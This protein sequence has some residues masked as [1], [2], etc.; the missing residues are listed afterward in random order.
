M[1]KTYADISKAIKIIF[2]EQ[3]NV[4]TSFVN[5]LKLAGLKKAYRVKALKHHPDRAETLGI[6]SGLLTRRFMLIRRAYDILEPYASGQKQLPTARPHRVKTV[7]RR[8]QRRAKAASQTKVRTGNTR[9][10]VKTRTPHRDKAY[11]TSVGVTDFYFKGKMPQRHM[12]FGQFLYYRK[13][14]SWRMM[15]LAVTWQRRTRP[16]IGDIA[17]EKGWLAQNQANAISRANKL[18]E[19]WGETAIRLGFINP[20]QLSA[21]L[22]WQR[23]EY[24]P[25]GRYFVEQFIMDDDTLHKNLREHIA[26]NYRA[27][28]ARARSESA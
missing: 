2:G 21:L 6:D 7:K 11:A 4:S 27:R 18:G 15:I 28:M 23:L 12:R 14:I 5:C 10:R 19:L 25:I 17:V 13:L 8:K 26:H 1:N 24:S 22:G 16:T 20:Y 3:A 9:V